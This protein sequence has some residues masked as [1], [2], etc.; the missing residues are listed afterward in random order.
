MKFVCTLVSVFFT[1]SSVWSQSCV[2]WKKNFGGSN[3]ENP[4][5]V[6]PT[7]DGGFIVIGNAASNDG[8]I[9]VAHGGMDIWVIKLNHVGM[10][11]W[12]KTIGGS[13]DDYPGAIKQTTDGGYIITGTT[14][15]TDGDVIDKHDNADA[16]VV[17]LGAEGMI[18][19]QKT[20]GGSGNDFGYSVQIAADSSFIVTGATNSSDGDLDS[21]RGGA[22]YMLAKISKEG[23]LEW[24]HTYGGSGEDISAYVATTTDGGYIL[25]GS[26]NSSDGIITDNHGAQ[27]YWIIKTDSEGI[28]VWQKSYGGNNLDYANMIQPTNDGGYVVCGMTYSDDQYITGNHGGVDY[29][30]IKLDDTG[31][32][33]W[34]RAL[35]GSKDDYAN[36]IKKTSDGGYIVGGY[37]N[38][39]DSMVTGYH[40]STDAW[41]VKL[42]SAGAIQW[43]KTYG[44]TRIDY[45]NWVEP[46]ADGGYIMAISSQSSDCDVTN[47]HGDFDFFIVKLA[48]TSTM[49]TQVAEHEDRQEVQI[50]PIPVH[51]LL[52]IAM[53]EPNSTYEITDVLGKLLISGNIVKTDCEINMSQIAPG[54][55]SI[56]VTDPNG[57]HTV[58]KLVKE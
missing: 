17:K 13:D 51:S 41:V 19:W 7:M 49:P 37:T 50:Y 42:S 9:S 2:M 56:N 5:C 30:I 11:Q 22:D 24:I 43:Q 33:Q 15:S 4:T 57:K 27:D 40:D 54:Y 20:I 14:R 38:S 21:N 28:M 25:C 44:G 23:T 29:W 47:N 36:S 53:A 45:A 58:V 6:Q 39:N 26:S 10:K 8:D 52:H 46:T 18:E 34:Q 1:M 3:T 12:E 32:M 55:Y 31:A 48:G 35:G 16:W